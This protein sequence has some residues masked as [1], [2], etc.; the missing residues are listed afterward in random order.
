MKSIFIAFGLIVWL[1]CFCVGGVAAEDA[2]TEKKFGLSG[3]LSVNTYSSYVDKVSGEAIYN[4]PV[5]HPNLLVEAKP[6]GVYLSIG[7]YTTS[8]ASIN[9]Q[10]IPWN[11]Q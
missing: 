4:K 10:P 9:I 7:I 8:R 2:Q 6:W 11:M 1:L 5:I 3:Y